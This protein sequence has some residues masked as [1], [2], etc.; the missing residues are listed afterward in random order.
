[1]LDVA[2][3]RLGVGDVRISETA[4]A[5]VLDA[6]INNRL[7]YGKWSRQFER[8]FAD[9]HGRRFACF[10]N[11][12]TDALRIGLAA[13]KEK[14]NWPDGSTVLVPALT[15]VASVNVITQLNLKPYF[16]DVDEFYGMDPEQVGL[17]LARHH[18]SESKPMPVA[19]MPVHLFGQ[20]ASMKLHRLADFFGLRV[21]ADSCETMFVPGCAAGDVSCFSTYACHV[22]QTGVGGLA[23]TNDPE[24][25]ALI[26][27]YANHGR[28]GI[29]TG[30]DD[31]LGSKEVMDA[32]F[33]FERQGFSSRAT[34]LE[35]AIGCAELDDYES[36]IKRRRD[37]ADT[38]LARLSGLPLDL[39]RVRPGYESCWMMFPVLAFT[40]EQR[41]GLVLHLES[42][43]IETR[44]MLPLTSQ[45]YFKQQFGDIE[46]NYPIAAHVNTHGFYV[47][48]H[49]Y[50][51]DDDINQMIDG[52]RSFYR[53]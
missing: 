39:P 17:I 50:L 40:Q 23:T 51:T 33:Q 49:P 8:R 24:L 41:D 11:S 13:L 9:I 19:M 5:N 21:I 37:I 7:S 34:E 26:R 16:V 53:K 29:Y 31:D 44:P 4:K 43:G 36:N 15:F 12:G 22:I 25:A 18:A 20:P 3:K 48:S 28:N 10:V 52:F 38:L 45:P 1:L 47:A 35:A 14:Y 32:R 46:K 2:T 42:R 30:I 6:L 27:S